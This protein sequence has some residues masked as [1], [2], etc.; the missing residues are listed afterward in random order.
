MPLINRGHAV[1]L[2]QFVTVPLFVALLSDCSKPAPPPAAIDVTTIK[3]T[4]RAATVTETFVG[5]TE[6]RNTIE[7]RP[8]VGGLLEKQIAND[9][10]TIKKGD[11]LF[12]IDS[13][14]YIAALAQARAELAQAQA[15]REQA[16]RDF[17]RVQPLLAM[18]AVSQQDY[19]AAQARSSASAA[20]VDAA[21]A[22]VKTAELNLG[23]T[24]ITSPID[25][26]MG[27]A[28]IRVG[29]LVAP[30]STLIATVYSVDPMY[31]DFGISEQRLLAFQRTLGRTADQNSKSPPPYR[32]I[33][34]DGYEYPQ[35]PKLNFIDPAVDRTTG[36]LAV[37]L[38]VANPQKMLRAGQFARIAMDTQQ[39]PDAL[40]LPQRAV[41]DLQGS[42][43]V[44]VVDGDGK[45][46]N[47]DVKM[48]ARIEHDWQVLSG[49]KAGET[50][51]VD[52]VQKLKSGVPVHATPLPPDQTD[53]K[54]AQPG[55]P[56]PAAGATNGKP[57]E[58]PND[59]AAKPAKK[60][61]AA[62]ASGAAQ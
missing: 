47:R 8:R 16:E 25:G 48:G 14:P 33:L 23:Y 45:A 18:D 3:L 54:T 53:A 38:E 42:N 37:R 51:I 35:I 27:R 26:V 52:G 7:I 2:A 1:R 15:S 4:P 43:F 36:T 49:L 30:N 57:N 21:R 10:Q 6:A 60:A 50:V 61:P 28:E 41:Q 12:V 40:L 44:W 9:G 24:T 59:P 22:T 31:I 17:G 62:K 46:Q 19:D 5:Q 32:L 55:A 58:K 39:I 29:G 20:S 13:Q 56:Q 34:G 11:P